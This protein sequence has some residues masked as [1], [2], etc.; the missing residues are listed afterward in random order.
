MVQ[1]RIPLPDAA[2]ET[3]NP[4][5]VPAG[6]VIESCPGNAPPLGTGRKAHRPARLLREPGAVLCRI[7]PGDSHD[8]VA[9]TTVPPLVVRPEPLVL[10]VRDGVSDREWLRLYSDRDADVR[11]AATAALLA[12]DYVRRTLDR[13]GEPHARVEYDFERLGPLAIDAVPELFRIRMQGGSAGRIARHVIR[14][15]LYSGEIADP[16]LFRP[17]LAEVLRTADAESRAEAARLLAELGPETVPLLVPALD[18]PDPGVRRAAAWALEYIGVDRDGAVERLRLALEDS[19][20]EV[21]VMAAG[22]L[23]DLGEPTETVLPVLTAGL[24]SPDAFVR[25]AAVHRIGG[26]GLAAAGARPRLIEALSDP[27]EGV[28]RAVAEALGETGQAPEEAVEA[29]LATVWSRDPCDRESAVKA[30]RDLL[31]SGEV[32]PRLVEGLRHSD[33]D[34]RYAAADALGC[35]WEGHESALP[36]LIS[37]LTDP[38]ARVREKA[39][40]AIGLLR[41]DAVSAVPTLERLL[42]DPE[43][44]VRDLAGWAL[45]KVGQW[46][47]PGLARMLASKD[48][49]E[50][51]TALD[52]LDQVAECASASVPAL[53]RALRHAEPWT[54]T[55]AAG[56]LGKIGPDAAAA[57]PS[58]MELLEDDEAFSAAARAL[59]RIGG[60]ARTAVPE[61]VRMLDRGEPWE[62]F[63][64]AEALS[65]FGAPEAVPSLAELVRSEGRESSLGSARVLAQMAPGNPAADA[66]MRTALAKGNFLVR[67]EILSALT[68]LGDK[69]EPQLLLALSHADHFV[70]RKAVEGLGRI[71]SGSSLDAVQGALQD[72]DPGTRILAAMVLAGANSSDETTILILEQARSN[73][74]IHALRAA[75]ALLRIRPELAWP[76]DLVHDALTSSDDFLR[77]EAA[78]SLAQ[79]GAPSGTVPWLEAARSRPFSYSERW[80]Q[81]DERALQ[82]AVSRAL[83]R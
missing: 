77:L 41:E 56:V 54:R 23:G 78:L 28:R 47:I 43:T 29:L 19:S 70:R 24:S 75:T 44:K 31:E 25:G 10:G 83:G 16:D 62:R 57:V 2:R 42:D 9:G 76:R 27:D 61:L 30:L 40:W 21:R 5:S 3:T 33:P 13:L 65:L 72:P 26:L 15:M 38:D 46:G 36:D 11:E 12:L 79:G 71:G 58:L 22:A 81:T 50:R 20:D 52:R 60:A 17:L 37:A 69:A 1:V 53:V 51:H 80:G 64:V 39:C 82:D 67:R 45:W 59:A 18:D 14:M 63:Y 32:V 66:E 4:P 49:R 6:L 55:Q 74:G 73:S 34:R 35:L 68:G 7:V 48:R 8:R